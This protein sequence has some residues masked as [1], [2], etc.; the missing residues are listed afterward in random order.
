[1]LTA[2]LTNFNHGR[3][4]PRSLGSIL[5]QTR[6]PD[7]VIVIDDASTDDSIAIIDALLPGFP[8]ARLVR[9]LVNQGVIAN[10]N[11]GLRLARGEYVHFAAADDVFYRR[12]YEVGMR[13]LEQHPGAAL[14]SARSDLIDA[15]GRKPG[16]V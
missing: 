16:L 15:A 10:L 8:N 14:F 6:P 9:N 4:L 12:L 2:V 11:D 13:L 7:E 5:E 1:M 3:Y